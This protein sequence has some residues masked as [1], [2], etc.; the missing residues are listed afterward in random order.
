MAK[1]YQVI[2]IYGAK[3]FCMPHNGHQIIGPELVAEGWH[4][5]QFCRRELTTEQTCGSFRNDQQHLSLTKDGGQRPNGPQGKHRITEPVKFENRHTVMD[6]VT[7]PNKVLKDGQNST[8]N[9][10]PS[11]GINAGKPSCV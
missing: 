5:E 1:T 6:A 4:H 8:I 9:E 2:S 11:H 3:L 10:C 7:R